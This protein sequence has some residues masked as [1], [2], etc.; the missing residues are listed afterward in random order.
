[1]KTFIFI[2]CSFILG[3]I[4]MIIPLPFESHWCKPEWMTLILI[5]W[6]VFEPRV[7]GIG[8]AFCV[9]L[10]MDGLK[11]GLL[12]QTALSMTIVAY[13]AQ[14]LGNRL[15]LQPFWNQLLCVLV[16]VGLGQLVLVL[17][18]CSMGYPPT[19]LLVWL[20]TF[21]SLIVWP[22]IFAML[23]RYRHPSSRF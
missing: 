13:L 11:G 1:M 15:R 16:L 23:R 22:G 10:L 4:L 20:S 5:F 6:I 2:Y 3:A 18:R 7:V 12:G 9:G 8:T 19:T 14:A 21:T 17:I